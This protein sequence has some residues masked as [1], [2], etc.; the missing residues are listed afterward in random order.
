[1]VV[2]EEFYLWF[3]KMHKFRQKLGLSL[4]AVAVS[5]CLAEAGMLDKLAERNTTVSAHNDTL[6]TSA[7]LGNRS[8]ADWNNVS[9]IYVGDRSKDVRI[10]LSGAGNQ[11][12]GGL[13]NETNGEGTGIGTSFGKANATIEPTEQHQIPD[14]VADGE[15]N[16]ECDEL[17]EAYNALLWCHNGRRWYTYAL[18]SLAGVCEVLTFAVL[19]LW[20]NVR[21][22]HR[23]ALAA[24]DDRQQ[25]LLPLT[26]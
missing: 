3:C 7:I 12:L 21:R 25:S 19:C 22:K 2:H 15:H 5:A 1:M 10:N 13:L 11:S 16:S 24:L 26:P 17:F 23:D 9:S 8:R 20:R 18:A 4:A 14:S 6:N